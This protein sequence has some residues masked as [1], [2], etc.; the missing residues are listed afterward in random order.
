MKGDWTTFVSAVWDEKGRRVDV[1]DRHISEGLK[2]AATVL[3]YPKNRGIPIECVD[4]HSLRIGGA[5]A[6]HL[7]GYS[8][9]E[10]Q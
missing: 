2:L 6:L 3:Q 7:A 5:N 9:R 1:T 8:D 4:T 10:I